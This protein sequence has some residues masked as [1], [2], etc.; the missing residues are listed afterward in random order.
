M[1]GETRALPRDNGGGRDYQSAPILHEGEPEHGG[2]DDQ[3]GDGDGGGVDIP[4]PR[5]GLL[6]RANPAQ[7]WV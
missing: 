7:R 4:S 2:D 3:D 5:A 6:E 1:C